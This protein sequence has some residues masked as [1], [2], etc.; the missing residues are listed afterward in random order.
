MIILK[1][2]PWHRQV[3]SPSLVC[4]HTCIMQPLA[5][6]STRGSRRP[7]KLTQEEREE[8]AEAAAAAL[9]DPGLEA[10]LYIINRAGYDPRVGDSRH[11][12]SQCAVCAA[13]A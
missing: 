10:G 1:P 6:S 5:V 11:G 9:A 12:P 8:A 2:N 13:A 3:P 7:R 4:V